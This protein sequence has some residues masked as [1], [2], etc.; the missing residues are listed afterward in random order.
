M[1]SGRFRL[2]PLFYVHG[3][4]AVNSVLRVFILC[5]FCV[6]IRI[7][8]VGQDV[9]GR[10]GDSGMVERFFSNRYEGQGEIFEGLNIWKDKKY[11]ALQGTYPVI[12][13]SF[14]NVKDDTY[15]GTKTRICQIIAD[16][17]LR[18]AFKRQRKACTT[19]GG[20]F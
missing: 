15:E 10:K 5:V 11:R 7:G 12:S 17:Y 14:A 13:L 6:S 20:V 8:G 19:G 4:L 16:V 18:N 1:G 2:F 3:R 9:K